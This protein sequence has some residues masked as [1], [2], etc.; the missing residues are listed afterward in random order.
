MIS[1]P[2]IPYPRN[3]QFVR[4]WFAM[5]ANDLGIVR[6]PATALPFIA[7]DL[8]H[9]LQRRPIVVPNVDFL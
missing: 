4:T 5:K 9:G 8:G 3:P 7:I 6:H 2:V 1:L